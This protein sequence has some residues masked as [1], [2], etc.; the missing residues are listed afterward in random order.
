MRIP[1]LVVALLVSGCGAHEA[2]E[3]RLDLWVG[4]SAAQLVSLWGKPHAVHIRE[5]GGRVIEYRGPVAVG[6][7]CETRFTTSD[8]GFI[9]KWAYYGND[10]RL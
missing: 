4:R 7:F 1:F 5:D 8:K 6:L 9:E 2:Y 3:R 10:C